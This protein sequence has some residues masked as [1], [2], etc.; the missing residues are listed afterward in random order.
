MDLSE[1]LVLKNYI[2]VDW[3]HPHEILGGARKLHNAF[4]LYASNR[5]AL[6]LALGHLGVAR[7]GKL[8]MPCI[9]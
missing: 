4:R 1:R 2:F 3:N 6:A 5:D 9:I 7:D 8:F